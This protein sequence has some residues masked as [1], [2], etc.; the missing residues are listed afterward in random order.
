VLRWARE[1]HHRQ[2]A[3]R[4]PSATPLGLA[5]TDELGGAVSEGTAPTNSRCT[6]RE[7]QHER[8]KSP[9]LHGREGPG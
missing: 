5:S 3:A 8:T 4:G 1:A 9:R 2:R 6:R 7:S